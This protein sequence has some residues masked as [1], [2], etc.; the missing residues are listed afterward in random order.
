MLIA[1]SYQNATFL[2]IYTGVEMGFFDREGVDLDYVYVLA[3][4]KTKTTELATKGEVAFLDGVSTGVTAAVRGW[5]QAKVVCS[6]LRDGFFLMVRPDIK[7]VADLK[8]KRIMT[9]GKGGRSFNEVFYICKQNGWKLGSDITII[10]GNQTDRIEAFQD[11]GIDAVAARTQFWF[12]AEQHGF[13]RLF[14]EDNKCWYSGGIVTTPRMI[15]EKP[16][17]VH[18]VVKVYVQAIDYIKS[19]R[20]EAIRIILKNVPYLDAEGASGNYDVLHDLWNPLLE[21][22]GVNYM[23]RICRAGK[24][25][26]R[27]PGFTDI[28]DLKFLKE[29]DL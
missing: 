13:R 24:G 4:N 29:L 10:E 5:G 21:P 20:D 28:V 19:N 18:A 1:L 25:E 17:V 12:W 22:S 8:G 26:Y 11:P 3:G 15:A 14:Y 6:G 7:R 23:V 2:P 27:T 16:E 9:G